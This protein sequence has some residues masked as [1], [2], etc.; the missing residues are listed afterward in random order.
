VGECRVT[1][2]NCIGGVTQACIPGTPG[3]EVCDGKDN[4]C[5]NQVDENLVRDCTSIC[6]TGTETCV[7]GEWINCTAPIP[8]CEGEISR[9]MNLL[10]GWNM[11]SLPVIPNKALVQDLFP[12]SVVAFDFDESLGYFRMEENMEME[13]GVGYWIL[14]N[15]DQNFIIT[16]QPLLSYN[17]SRDKAGWEMIGGCSADAKAVSENCVI[18]LYKFEQCSGYQWILESENLLPGQAYWIL[19]DEVVGQCNLTVEI[20]NP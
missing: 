7:N 9:E 11:I 12:G 13:P 10:K 8:P 15:E 1:V 6:G 18:I 14:L 4:D 5:D 19:F 2:Q 16:G 3:S 17:Y 20:I